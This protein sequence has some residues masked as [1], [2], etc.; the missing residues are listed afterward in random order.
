M[1]PFPEPDRSELNA[2]YWDGLAEGALRFQ[3]CHA[4][5]HAW[6]PARAECP[7][8]LQADNSWE[9]ASGDAKLVSWVTYH[10]AYHPAFKER[11]PYTVLLVEL[12]EGPR[13]IAGVSGDGELEIEQKLTLRI[14]KEGEL[15]LPRFA[16]I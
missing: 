5:S 7:R 3:R 1:E 11:V 8:C 16:K 10:T 2:P 15:S 9:D 12:A 6:L 14:E 13:M 4:C